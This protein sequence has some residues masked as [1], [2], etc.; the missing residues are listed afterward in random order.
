[1]K[2]KRIFALFA[3]NCSNK[4]LICRKLIDVSYN[5]PLF[6]PPPFSSLWFGAEALPR[7]TPLS[8]KRPSEQQSKVKLQPL[9]CVRLIVSTAAVRRFVF[10]QLENSWQAKMRKTIPRVAATVNECNYYTH[11]TRPLKLCVNMK[12]CCNTLIHRPSLKL[13]LPWFLMHNSFC[14]K[15]CKIKGK[16][17]L[18]L[19]LTQISHLRR[20]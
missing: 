4:L 11:V 2:H 20:L 1:M 3:L 17:K 10:F 8:R 19:Q 15:L 6:H 5:C 18:L 16:Y 13:L 9:S 7:I 14:V 12:L